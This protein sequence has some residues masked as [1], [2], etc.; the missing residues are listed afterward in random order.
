MPP[1]CVTSLVDAVNRLRAE[2]LTNLRNPGYLEGELLPA[3][4]LNNEMLHEFPQELYPYCGQGV[5]SWQYPSQFSRYLA[6][7]SYQHIDSYLE[8]GCRHGGT[9]IITVEYLR[10]FQPSVRATAI[11]IVQSPVMAEYAAL[12]GPGTDYQIVS[13]QSEEFAACVRSAGMWGLVLIDGDHSLGACLRD[14][15][16]VKN[17][18]RLVALHDICSSVCPGVVQVWNTI[19]ITH[20]QRNLVEFVDQYR[21][22]TERTVQTYLGMGVVRME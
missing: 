20:P 2:S 22:V 16:T 14:F 9:F 21:D 1:A 6:F 17:H 11:D 19:K 4:G 7:L 3:L 8:I 10:R 13:S 12:A 18:A 5:R 15:L